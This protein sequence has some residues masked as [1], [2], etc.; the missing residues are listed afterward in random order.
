MWVKWFEYSTLKTMDED[1]AE[2]ACI[3]RR[4]WPG[5]IEKEK[6]RMNQRGEEKEIG[7][8]KEEEREKMEA[9]NTE[10]AETR[11]DRIGAKNPIWNNKFV[12]RLLRSSSSAKLLA[13]PSRFVL[14]LTCAII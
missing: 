7:E 6:Q 11:I 2:E 12:S 8:L 5:S 1:L 10:K 3:L 14:L 4:L 9:G 13:F